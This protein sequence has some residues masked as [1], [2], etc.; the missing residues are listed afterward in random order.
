M[1]INRSN[2]TRRMDGV[3]YCSVVERAVLNP[4]RGRPYEPSEPR[5]QI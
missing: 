5:E 2:K 3:E 1:K 4:A